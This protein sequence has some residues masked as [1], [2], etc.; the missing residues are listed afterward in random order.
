MEAE[1]KAMEEEAKVGEENEV[2][3][4]E[5]MEAERKAMEEEASVREVARVGEH[6]VGAERAATAEVVKAEE[7]LV[8]VRVVGHMY[9]DH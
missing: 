5:V 6:G 3:A 7:D 8:E 1:R 2:E 4:E 9:S